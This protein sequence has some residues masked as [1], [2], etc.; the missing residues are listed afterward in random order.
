MNRYLIILIVICLTTSVACHT[1]AQLSGPTSTSAQSLHTAKLHFPEP[2]ADATRDGFPLQSVQQIEVWK[3]PNSS[4][5]EFFFV[6]LP[7]GDYDHQ[8]ELYPDIPAPEYSQNSFAVSFTESPKARVANRQEWEGAS[9]VSTR[10]RYLLYTGSDDSSGEIEYRGQKYPKV[11]KYWGRGFM[12]PGGKWLAVFSYTAVKP[13]PS[14]FFGSSPRSG[15]IFWEIYDTVTG[16]KV[17]EWRA[18]NVKSPTSLDGP[19]VWLEERY[20]LFPEDEDAQNF[21]V[22]TLPNFT[23]EPNPVTVHL[24]SRFDDKGQRLP[25]AVRHEAWTPLVPLTKEQAKRITAPSPTEISEVRVS[26]PSTPREL[27]LAIRE[28]TENS[29]RNRAGGDGAG[30]YNLRVFSTYYYAVSLD[31]PMQSRSASK[32]EWER[33]RVLRSGSN[34]ISLDE[35]TD[36]FGGKRRLYRPFPKTGESWGTPQ[37]FGAGEWVAV[38]SYTQQ[39][40]ETGKLFVDIFERRSGNKLSS[41]ELSY[42]GSVNA[43]FDASVWIEE[44]YLIVPL[45][46][47]F[48]SFVFWKLPGGIS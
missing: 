45:H 42:S 3:A 29:T 43:L 20:F 39:T 4:A 2:W 48:R 18:K 31:Q 40:K 6:A 30:N 16:Q 7:H 28:E 46:T 32:D 17:F 15:D 11:G 1:A 5:D 47:S 21:I 22:V 23:P 38:F 12:S 14:I 10:T 25:A 8:H 34:K 24:P 35:T 19:L 9:R 41:T 44:G 13:P 33:G 27:L 26:A 36:T 37:A